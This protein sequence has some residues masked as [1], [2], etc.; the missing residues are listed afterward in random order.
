MKKIYCVNHGRLNKHGSGNIDTIYECE[1]L[2]DAESFFDELKEEVEGWST[3]PK[4]G[5]CIV[6]QIQIKYYAEHEYE[7]DLAE[8]L[9]DKITESCIFEKENYYYIVK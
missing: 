6:T 3:T 1:K 4:T 9:N 2:E 5:D 8:D 7:I